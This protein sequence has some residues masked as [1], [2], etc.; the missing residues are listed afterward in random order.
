MKVKELPKLTIIGLIRGYQAALSPFIGN[1]CRFHPTCSA[2]AEDA[3][4]THGALR[5][6]WLALCRLSRCQPFNPGGFDPVPAPHGG[7][8]KEI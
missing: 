6:G 2:Y 4:M 5:G 8:S 1:R 7:A 3:V